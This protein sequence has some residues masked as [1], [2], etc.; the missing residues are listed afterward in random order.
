LF[1]AIA[2][3][4]D[5]VSYTVFL[6]RQSYQRGIFAIDLNEVYITHGWDTQSWCNRNS[7]EKRYSM[8]LL[9]VSD[10]KRLDISLY[11]IITNFHTELKPQAK[12]AMA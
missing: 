11:F 9:S 12:S 8:F 7:C 3:A 1:K 5:K 10:Y 2:D 4:A 6:A